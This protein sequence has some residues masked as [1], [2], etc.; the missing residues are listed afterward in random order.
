[1]WIPAAWL[2][3]GLL[4]VPPAFAAFSPALRKRMYGV[5]EDEVL[6]LLL[7]HRGVLFSAVATACAYAAFNPDGRKVAS[8]VT[9]ISVL[10]FLIGFLAAGR[11]P[12][13]RTIGIADAVG[14][15]PLAG[16]ILNAWL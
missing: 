4:H 13:L 14:V 16:V 6:G 1:M 8:L 12:R 10:G 3:L 9:G 15:I 2:S 11:P 5:E 7:G